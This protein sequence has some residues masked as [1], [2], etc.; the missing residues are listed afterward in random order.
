MIH[1]GANLDIPFAKLGPQ[2]AYKSATVELIV[3]QLS[4]IQFTDDG[5]YDKAAVLPMKSEQSWI[6]SSVLKEISKYITVHD[7]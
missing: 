6:P 5:H 2:N 1:L 4:A 7:G 3:R